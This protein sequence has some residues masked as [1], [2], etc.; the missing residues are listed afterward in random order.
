MRGLSISVGRHRHRD[1][2]K[3]NAFFFEHFFF[4]FGADTANISRLFDPVMNFQR[5][6][7]EITSDIIEIFRNEIDNLFARFL[8]IF[9]INGQLFGDL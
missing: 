1:L 7:C 9:L 4:F 3:V 5:F 6:F 2:K 8:Q